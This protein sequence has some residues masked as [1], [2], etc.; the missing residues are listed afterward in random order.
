LAFF[1]TLVSRRLKG[2]K[3]FFDDRAKKIE[4]VKQ[5]AGGRLQAGRDT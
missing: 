5:S 3:G 1:A 2:G 4:S